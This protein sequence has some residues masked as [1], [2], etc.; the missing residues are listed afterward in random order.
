M[1]RAMALEHIPDLIISDLMIPTMDGNELCK[2]LKQDERTAHIPIIML[3][4]KASQQDRMVGLSHGAID[5]ITKPFNKKELLLKLRNLLT[6]RKQM[7]ENI[8]KE[9]QRLPM[10]SPA[11]MSDQEKFIWKLKKYIMDHLDDTDMDVNSVGR[12]MG[13]GRI[14]LYRKVLGLTGLP[15]SDFIRHIR[16]HRAAELL[17]KKWGSVSE[18]AYAVGFN[19]LSYFTRSFK[20]IYK[21]TPSQ[22]AKSKAVR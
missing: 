16:I 12:A 8:R 11:V 7:Q 10:E 9:L 17:Q 15:T 19:N 1:G 18:V 21:L 2:L 14:Q 3:T 22:Y 5:Y 13:Y 4:A 20:E 6:Q